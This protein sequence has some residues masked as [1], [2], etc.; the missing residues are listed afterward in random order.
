MT[1][2]SSPEPGPSRRRALLVAVAVGALAGGGLWYTGRATQ[3]RAVDA[4]AARQTPRH[5]VEPEP[6]TLDE[7]PPQPSSGGTDAVQL[8]AK[9]PPS[10]GMGHACSYRPLDLVPSDAKA[11]AKLSAYEVEVE[12]GYT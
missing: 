4:V 10:G 2:P 7:A 1:T 8:A 5:R 11:H 12:N 3:Q 9:A 6:A